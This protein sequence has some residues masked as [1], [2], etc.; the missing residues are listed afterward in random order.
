[1]QKSI[2]DAQERRLKALKEQQYIKECKEQ[3]K[4]SRDIQ[5][6]YSHNRGNSID[7]RESFKDTMDKINNVT[8]RLN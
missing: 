8:Q 5:R 3:G 4:F 6:Q 1:M 2:K 7:K